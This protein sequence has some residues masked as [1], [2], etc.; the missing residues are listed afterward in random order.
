MAP[1]PAP[2]RSKPTGNHGGL[3][4]PQDPFEPQPGVLRMRVE[5]TYADHPP[6]R[7][8]AWW[9]PVCSTTPRWLIL[10]QLPLRRLGNAASFEFPCTAPWKRAKNLWFDAAASGRRSRLQRRP[11]TPRLHA[12]LPPATRRAITCPGREPQRPER[13]DRAPTRTRTW[14]CC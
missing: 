13:A 7:R 6:P 3:A 11:L 8:L 14:R 5:G 9:V 2:S 1:L 12:A 10:R 4:G